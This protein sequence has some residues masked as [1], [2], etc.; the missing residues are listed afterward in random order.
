MKEIFLRYHDKIKQILS[1]TIPTDLHIHP[2]NPLQKI[3][4][5][6]LMVSPP[7]GLGIMAQ[8]VDEAYL[9]QQNA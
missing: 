9:V 6:S 3:I 4:A 1:E 8:D 5:I 2:L 7:P